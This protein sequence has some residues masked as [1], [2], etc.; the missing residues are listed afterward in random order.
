MKKFI[1]YILNLISIT[2]P[3]FIKSNHLA[4]ANYKY[5]NYQLASKRLVSKGALYYRVNYKVNMLEYGMTNDNVFF[6]LSEDINSKLIHKL[7][8]DLLFDYV[9]FIFDDI[10]RLE[11]LEN[12]CNINGNRIRSIYI[13]VIIMTLRGEICSKYVNS[14]K[15]KPKLLRAVLIAEKQI[16]R[17]KGVN[18]EIL[19]RVLEVI[20]GGGL[21]DYE[22]VIRF[23]GGSITEY[24]IK[25]IFDL[26]RSY[27]DK[28]AEMIISNNFRELKYLLGRTAV[29]SLIEKTNDIN[30]YVK[31]Y[32]KLFDFRLSSI[33]SFLF[34]SKNYNIVAYL[35]RTFS[36]F[37]LYR[38]FDKRLY[39]VY[40]S[41]VE[42]DVNL[43]IKYFKKRKELNLNT[44]SYLVLNSLY[45]GDI[46]RAE[47]ER[48]NIESSLQFYIESKICRVDVDSFN[49]SESILIIA[50]QGVADEVRWARLYPILAKLDKSI[51]ITCDPRFAEIFSRSFPS[52]NFVPHQRLFRKPGVMN[53]NDFHSKN[54]PNEFVGR[55]DIIMSTSMMFALINDIDTRNEPYLIVDKSKQV[56]ATDHK[57]INVGLLWSSS[58]SVGLRQHRYGIP[59]DTY[60]YLM[61]KLESGDFRF[62]CLQS[63]VMEEDKRFCDENDIIIPY[64][65]DLYNDFDASAAFLESLD[66]VIGPSSLLTELSAAVGT[67]FLHVANAPEVAY[68]RCGD[69][70]KLS[71][72]DQLSNNTLT[73][74]PKDGYR[75][76][77]EFINKQ[78]IDRAIYTMKK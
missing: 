14:I 26:I 35:V 15:D 71:T 25:P 29:L 4:Y 34:Y 8:Y 32:I 6:I 77:K 44:S 69:I 43:A 73:M 19:P 39:F 57:K 11:Y 76:P 50:E 46:R 41:L 53:I 5:G 2:L 28:Y 7:P 30:L 37:N 47:L 45:L 38:V 31:Y 42:C 18:E 54:F 16:K 60:K 49:E 52:L 55:F 22:E 36:Y 62:Y 64:G 17:K 33:I 68:M 74:F 66:Y 23:F 12:I 58:L 24:N 61:E 48:S 27:P 1:I 20:D 3:R 51:S 75:I 78:C 13:K 63:P 56:V 67:K 72:C 59:N 70:T 21:D 10:I 65:V 40:L 9:E